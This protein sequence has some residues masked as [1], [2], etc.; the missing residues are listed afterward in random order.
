MVYN[1]AYMRKYTTT[2]FIS[3]AQ[4]IHKN[5][6]DY[7]E[8]KYFGDSKNITIICPKHGKFKQRA[9]H[10]KK[11]CG[12]PKCK[13]EK[14]SDVRRMSDEIFFEICKNIH[15]NYYSYE[16]SNYTKANNKI[17]IICPKHG[18]F[19]QK[20]FHHKSGHKCPLCSSE[21]NAKN[22]A[23]T[24]IEFIQKAE[25]VHKNRYDYSL[26]Q[27][28]NTKTKVKIIC[29]EHGVFRQ[30]PSNHLS[31]KGCPFC[32]CYSKAEKE[33][34]SI[35]IE[36]KIQFIFQKAFPYFL[37]PLGN[38]YR[39]DFYLPDINSIIE[40]DGLHHFSPIQKW[41][42]Q[43]YLAQTKKR[44][45]SKNEYCRKNNIEMIRINFKQN[46]LKEL[47]RNKII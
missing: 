32:N 44:D 21:E 22:Q 9:D 43:K 11:G 35:L 28:K 20:A 3:Q 34:A 18:E 6:Y 19:T 8:T 33:I 1:Y 41:G 23:L 24:K 5:K 31:G 13:N 40:Y 7:S 46:I 2:E 25:N 30:Q 38:P 16:K 37:T 36:N 14:I 17:I 10:H 45:E 26:V 27:Y 29:K 4:K 42:G 15:D 39:F 12:C 47:K